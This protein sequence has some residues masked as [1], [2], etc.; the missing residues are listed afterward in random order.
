LEL[1]REILTP[2]SGKAGLA[3]IFMSY[4]YY[5]ELKFAFLVSMR[6]FGGVGL[7][8][9]GTSGIEGFLVSI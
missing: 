1:R 5:F 9:F 3:H 7:I 4:F 8:G 2:K 6:V